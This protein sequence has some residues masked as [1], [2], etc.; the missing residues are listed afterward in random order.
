MTWR[1][2]GLYVGENRGTFTFEVQHQQKSVWRFLAHFVIEIEG[3][4]RP[5]GRVESTILLKKA[6]HQLW[7]QSYRLCNLADGMLKFRGS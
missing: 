2:N 1:E 6:L 5:T 7:N 4:V 3:N